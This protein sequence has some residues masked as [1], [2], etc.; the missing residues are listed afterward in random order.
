MAEDRHSL[1]YYFSPATTTTAIVVQ[2][3]PAAT[4][5]TLQATVFVAL[6]AGTPPPAPVVPAFTQAAV[7]PLAPFASQSVPV[8]VPPLPVVVFVQATTGER[9]YTRAY[10]VVPGIVPPAAPTANPIFFAAPPTSRWGTRMSGT[11]WTASQPTSR[12]GT[13]MPIGSIS[14]VSLEDV[15]VQ[16]FVKM[17]GVVPNISLDTVQMAF[18]PMSP[19]EPLPEPSTFYTG[20]WDVDTTTNPTTY[21]ALCLVGSGGAVALTAGVYA[22]YVKITD[23]PEHPVLFSGQL[24]VT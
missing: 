17:N 6:Q 21:K 2:S 18:V 12:W 7:T 13:R 1:L 9:L 10:Q 24:T 16:V 20:S 14:S 5:P 19:G 3:Q 11:R 23:N 8:V 4:V 22:V 15:A